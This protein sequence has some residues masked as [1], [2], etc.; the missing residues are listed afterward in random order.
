MI[1]IAAIFLFFIGLAHSI[2]GERYILVRLFRRD[3]LPKLL[4]SDFL[5]NVPY[6]SP[7]I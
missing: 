5:Q 2:L 4:G 7:G 1:E 3:N 6:G